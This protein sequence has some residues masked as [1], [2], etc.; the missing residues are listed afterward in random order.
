M[1]NT[2]SNIGKGVLD[3]TL[4]EDSLSIRTVAS[5][6]VIWRGSCSILKNS[7]VP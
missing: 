6:S 4:A 3:L 7:S 5:F 1:V 2:R